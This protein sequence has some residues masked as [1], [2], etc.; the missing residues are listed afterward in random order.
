MPG[1]AGLLPPFPSMRHGALRTAV[2]MVT[3]EV[4]GQ[5][6]QGSGGGSR[7]KDAPRGKGTGQAPGSHKARGKATAK[8]RGTTSANTKRKTKGKSTGSGNT[9]K[10]GANGNGA[11]PAPD[12]QQ[13][14]SA[15][16]D[17]GGGGPSGG[18]AKGGKRSRPQWGGEGDA[19]GHRAKAKAAAAAVAGEAVGRG[20]TVRIAVERELAAMRAPT[21][22]APPPPTLRYSRAPYV[23]DKPK[24]SECLA[25]RA[26]G[27]LMYDFRP[28]GKM[29][30]LFSLQKSKRGELW[31][32]LGGKR[33]LIDRSKPEETAKRELY[34][35]TGGLVVGPGGSFPCAV[36]E[37]N[38]LYVVYVARLQGYLDLPLRFALWIAQGNSCWGGQSTSALAWFTM[39]ELLGNGPSEQHQKWHPFVQ[40]LRRND[41]LLAYL[42]THQSDNPHRHGRAAEETGAG[43]GATAAA[44]AAAAPC[45]QLPRPLHE[46]L[47][48]LAARR[49]PH[50]ERLRVVPP[51]EAVPLLPVRVPWREAPL[52][53]GAGRLWPDR[54]RG[55]RKK[56]KKKKKKGVKP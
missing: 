25:Y 53:P 10:A 1:A 38:G 50:G 32:V 15:K 56:K 30:L 54:R 55:R 11:K 13:P 27:V 20:R 48:A 29:V 31:N 7:P 26:A 41:K 17:A 43:A 5:K 34:E 39:K 37:P 18:A 23:R 4:A 40:Q 9:A 44:A 46:E 8:S 24:L 16:V 36:W 21:R 22:S 6:R 19:Q 3:A 12:E 2:L 28:D 42:R 49:G 52:C 51:W 14:A 47:A 33:S 35:E 45:E